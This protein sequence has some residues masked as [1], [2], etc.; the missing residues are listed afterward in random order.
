[1]KL[2]SLSYLLRESTDTLRRFPFPLASAAIATYLYILLIEGDLVFHVSLRFCLKLLII[3]ILGISL[4][5]GIA[6]AAEQR[7]WSARMGLAVQAGALLLLAAY[8]FSLPYDLT[9]APSIHY[10]RYSFWLV[11]MHFFVAI[12]PYMG[13]GRINGFWHYNKALFLRFLTASLYSTVLYTGLAVAILAVENLFSIDISWRRYLQ[14]W[15][16]IAGMFNTWFFLA[17]VPKQ[18]DDLDGQSDYPRGLKI[19]T[20]FVLIPLVTI[21]LLILYGYETKIIV[22]W[23]WPKGWV[24]YLVLAFSITGILSLLLVHPIRERIENAWIKVFSRGFYAALMPLAV[25]LLLAIWRRISEYGLTERRYAV[26]VLALWLAGIVI[27][28]LVKRDGSIKMI[29]MTLCLLSFLTSFGPWGAF[30]LSESNQVSRLEEVLTARGILVD[31]K[32]KPAKEVPFEDARRISSIVRYLNEV[33]GLSR[34]QQW[35]HVDLD[36]L[37]SSQIAGMRN[38]SLPSQIA[39]LMGIQYVEEYQMGEFTLV[40]FSMKEN[41]A[42]EIGTYSHVIPS[43]HLSPGVENR[44]FN[45]QGKTIRIQYQNRKN[46]LTLHAPSGESLLLDL[47]PLINRLLTTYGNSGYHSDLPPGALAVEAAS[48]GIRAKV[49]LNSVQISSSPDG[50]NVSW[51]EARILIDLSPRSK[52]APK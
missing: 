24:S 33:H 6:V 36:T 38:Y 22:E 23:S 30:A 27:Y 2:P 34:L 48:K 5:T 3:A 41:Q 17:G 19:F 18:I 11:G 45:L 50:P 10:I 43:F 46:T 13:K 29:P 25:L 26:I 39:R 40:N 16:V 52:G 35:F 4:F 15:A 44:T 7:R 9:D 14:L 20:Q 42:L 8:Y 32:I 21:Y 37:G 47:S 1:M 49:Y 12:A 51:G 31:G 28:F